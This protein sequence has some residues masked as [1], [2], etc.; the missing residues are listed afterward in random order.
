[1]VKPKGEARRTSEQHA[2][3]ASHLRLFRSR[4]Q[5]VRFLVGT[6]QL[7]LA[8]ETNEHSFDEFDVIL[9]YAATSSN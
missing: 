6:F 8:Q 3:W 5:L 7:A 9:A 2:G 1:M 4:W